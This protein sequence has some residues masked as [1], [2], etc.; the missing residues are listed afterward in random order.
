M[1]S[2]EYFRLKEIYENE[3][4][5]TRNQWKNLSK[6][7]QIY[8]YEQYDHYLWILY[9]E[10]KF[11]LIEL[12]HDIKIPPVI[13]DQ[14]NTRYQKLTIQDIGNIISLSDYQYI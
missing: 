4:M 14:Y 12:I 8:D 7:K 9:W 2:T 10:Y 11:E 5:K 1:N 6:K 3:K 13:R